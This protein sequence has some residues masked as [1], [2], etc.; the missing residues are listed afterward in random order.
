MEEEVVEGVTRA[1]ANEVV[2]VRERPVGCVVEGGVGFPVVCAWNRAALLH[3]VERVRANDAIVFN[4]A[5]ESVKRR[6]KEA[7]R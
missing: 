6:Y 1:I 5:F 2:G 3:S 4:L 7:S